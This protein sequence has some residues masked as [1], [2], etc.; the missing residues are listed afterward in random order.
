MSK[1]GKFRGFLRL[2]LFVVSAKVSD[3]QIE[4]D[5]NLVAGWLLE[6]FYLISEKRFLLYCDSFDSQASHC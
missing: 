1:R 2:E 4:S 6:E 5:F 3:P